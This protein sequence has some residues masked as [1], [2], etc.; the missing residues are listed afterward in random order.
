[1]VI[2]PV[3]SFTVNLEVHQTTGT[4]DRVDTTLP[5]TTF[6]TITNNDPA[7]DECK[8]TSCQTDTS[9]GTDYAQISE[10]TTWPNIAFQMKTDQLVFPA[11]TVCVRCFTN[12]VQVFTQDSSFSYEVANNCATRITLATPSSTNNYFTTNPPPLAGTTV[13]GSTTTNDAV[14]CP[15]SNA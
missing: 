7:P 10:T 8:F 15:L 6:F 14:L 4:A 13:V 11:T 3:T 1:V 5:Y 9:C 2:T 12:G